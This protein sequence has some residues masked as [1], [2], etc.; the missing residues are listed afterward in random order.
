MSSETADPRRS[1]T[2]DR[3]PL[4]HGWV[5]VRTYVRLGVLNVAQYR[6]EFYVALANV[7]TLATQFVGIA[8]IFANT[9]DLGGWTSAGLVALIGVYTILSGLIAMVI[10]PSLQQLMEGIRLGTFDFTLTKPADSQLL[11]SVAVVSP[12]QAL[13]IV[14]GAGIVGYACIRM[15]T[16]IGPLQWL[17]FC[18]TLVFGATIV[19]SFLTL[20]GTCAFWWVKV[21]N[22]LV[23]FSAVF[24]QA[25]RWPL[26]VFPGWMRVVLSLVIPVGLAVTIPAQ[27][28]AG[29][30]SGWLVLASGSVA[31]LFFVASRAF[32]RYAL[33][34]YTG[35]S[36]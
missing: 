34:H 2:V 6:G 29:G 7:I 31:A 36:A 33:R 25:G 15:G 18:L 27:A 16:M 1:Q 22:I 5:I 30:L 19:Y 12:A 32:W 9:S 28:L 10:Q 26:A 20:L 4:A 11:A 21:D 3:G 24:G 17:Y 8:V 13:N 14:F 23:V 35:A